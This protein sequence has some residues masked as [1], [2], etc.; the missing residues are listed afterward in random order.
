MYLYNLQLLYLNHEIFVRKNYRAPSKIRYYI[1]F[2]AF[3][4]KS[5]PKT[6][7]VYDFFKKNR[8]LQ[9]F[10]VNCLLYKYK[11]M[12]N[13]DKLVIYIVLGARYGFLSTG[14]LGHG[15]PL[16]FNIL[17]DIFSNGHT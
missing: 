17:K 16:Y 6:I 13:M 9:S 15:S 2:Q 12:G 10:T 14:R 3:S 8:F 11:L 1:S 4:S 7:F 5:F